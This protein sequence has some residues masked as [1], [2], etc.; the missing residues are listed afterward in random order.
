M[1]TT[2]INFLFVVWFVIHECAKNHIAKVT[3][4]NLICHPNIFQADL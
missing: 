2:P 3:P 1:R 4:G